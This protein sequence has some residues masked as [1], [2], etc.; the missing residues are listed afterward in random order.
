[1]NEGHETPS[2][3]VSAASILDAAFRKDR[4]ASLGGQARCLLCKRQD[5]QLYGVGS[6]RCWWCGTIFPAG[7]LAETLVDLAS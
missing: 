2:P 7:W 5:L 4:A 3:D 1:M 6:V